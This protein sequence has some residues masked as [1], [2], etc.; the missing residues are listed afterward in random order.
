LFVVERGM[1]TTQEI[2][3]EALALLN[4]VER[5]LD[6]HLST[7]HSLALVLQGGL[8]YLRREWSSLY[9]LELILQGSLGYVQREYQELVHLLGKIRRYRERVC[10]GSEEGN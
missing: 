8:E 3:D 2:N 4:E 7:V 6:M 9:P 1:A 10:V 5:R